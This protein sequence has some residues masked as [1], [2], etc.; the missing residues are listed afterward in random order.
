MEIEE[1]EESKKYNEY[2]YMSKFVRCKKCHMKTMWWRYHPNLGSVNFFAIN[3][4]Y[5]IK[6]KH[7]EH[8]DVKFERKPNGD[9]A[10]TCPVCSSENV[11][12]G[13]PEKWDLY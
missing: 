11:L 4:K 1:L 7:G 13:I 8:V 9:V 3:G 2:V 10:V 12:L 6:D 5:L